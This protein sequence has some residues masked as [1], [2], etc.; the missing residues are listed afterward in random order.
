MKKYGIIG[1]ILFFILGG[2]LT[3]V[4]KSW[5]PIE[6][7]KYLL[8]PKYEAGLC[9]RSNKHWGVNPKVIVGFKVTKLKNG[10]LLKDMDKYEHYQFISKLEVETYAEVIRCRAD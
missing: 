8:N 9:V 4:P 2:A 1:L 3:V 10:Y 6:Y 5:I 7:R